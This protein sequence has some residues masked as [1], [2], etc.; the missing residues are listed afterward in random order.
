MAQFFR[1]QQNPRLR[2]TAKEHTELSLHSGAPECDTC[3]S[4]LLVSH[5]IFELYWAVFLLMSGR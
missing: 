4:K 2:H 3:F 5:F 1:C